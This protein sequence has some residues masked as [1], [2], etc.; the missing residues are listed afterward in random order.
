MINKIIDGISIALNAEFGNDYEIY[1]DNIEQGLKEPCFSIVCLNPRMNQ[2][3]E[4]DISDK[5]SSVF[6]IFQNLR[7]VMKL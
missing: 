2:F 6:T 7:K 3:L 5:I 4:K 1:T